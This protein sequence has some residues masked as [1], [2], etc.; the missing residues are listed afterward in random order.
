[1][2]VPTMQRWP[3]RS[4]YKSKI[5]VFGDCMTSGLLLVSVDYRLSE[6]THARR[7]PH[8]PA[9]SIPRK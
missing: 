8:R 2:R 9:K 3:Y 5:L 4:C 1:M 6:R 7:E